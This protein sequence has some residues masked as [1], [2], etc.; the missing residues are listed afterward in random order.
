MKFLRLGLLIALICCG[1][2]CLGGDAARYAL[3]GTLVTP[4]EVIPDGTVLISGNKIEAVGKDV[5]V[6]D[7]VQIIETSTFIYPGL[8]DLHDHIMW[9]FL[10]RWNAGEK[11]INRYEW[12]ARDAYLPALKEPHD[13]MVAPSP[14]PTPQEQLACDINRYG[15]VKAIVGG[16]TAIVDSLG[17][18]VCVTGLVRNLD[19]N[20]GLYQAGS[21]E[22]LWNKVFP[23]EVTNDEVAKINNGLADHH[24][25]LIV[26]LAEGKRKDASAAREFRMF[27]AR[28]FLRDGVSIIHG[29]ALSPADF[30]DMNENSV[31]L[32]WSPRS[33]IEL[34]DETTD[35]RAAKEN[36]VKI[37]LAPDW[38]PTGSD[39]MLE[40]MKYAASWNVGQLPP[41]FTDQDIVQM[42]TVYAAQLAKLDNKIGSLTAGHFADLLVIQSSETDPYHALLSADPTQVQL[43]VIDGKPVYGEEKLMRSVEPAGKFEQVDIC[44]STK[45]LSLESEPPLNGKAPTWQDTVRTLELELRKFGLP[46]GELAPC[47]KDQPCH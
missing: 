25:A 7:G 6:P 39:G 30:K 44:G 11:F 29:V 46:V 45:Y 8:I 42:A 13:R 12:Q 26:H 31:G 27:K 2:F 33:N 28:G 14:R 32:I 22:Q 34:Y 18:D 21:D 19:S 23:L 4:T 1:D 40:E 24:H 36:G 41:V 38:S 15:E 20:S 9:N 43:V 37:A 47:F 17:K 3:K 5:H 35:V 16:A 10:P